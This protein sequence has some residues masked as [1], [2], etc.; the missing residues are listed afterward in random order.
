MNVR[1]NHRVVNVKPPM[2]CGVG[3]RSTLGISWTDA[4]GCT[5]T[6]TIPDDSELDNMIEQLGRRAPIDD[7]HFDR[8]LPTPLQTLSRKN[9]TGFED[10]RAEQELSRVLCRRYRV[11]RV[12]FLQAMLLPLIGR[13]TTPCICSTRFRQ[14]KARWWRRGVRARRA[15]DGG[16]SLREVRARQGLAYR[17]VLFPGFG[18]KDVDVIRTAVNGG[19]KSDKFRRLKI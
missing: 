18:G 19:P 15:H 9:W 8:I 6:W 10:G 17:V 1:P 14:E 3:A 12:R 13:S 11:G 5:S 7:A 4:T 2:F 16:G